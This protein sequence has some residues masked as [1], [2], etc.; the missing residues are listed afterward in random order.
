MAMKQ[1]HPEILHL[2]VEKIGKISSQWRLDLLY[3]LPS[4]EMQFIC[5][6]QQPLYCHYLLQPHCCY[7]KFCL[8]SFSSPLSWSIFVFFVK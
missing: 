8:S 2:T 4:Y 1:E 6:L 3:L 7:L 5:Q